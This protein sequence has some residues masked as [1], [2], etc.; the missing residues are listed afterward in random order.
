MKIIKCEFKESCP[1]YTESCFNEW[2][3]VCSTRF[4]LQL[5]RKLNSKQ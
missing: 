1:K 4:V 2:V 3:D 5:S